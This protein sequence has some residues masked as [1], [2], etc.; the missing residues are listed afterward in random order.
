MWNNLKYP[1]K[2]KK[3]KEEYVL[4]DKILGNNFRINYEFRLTWFR[5]YAATLWKLELK[6]TAENRMFENKNDN[7]NK[8]ST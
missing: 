2:I 7:N 8:D 3:R 1:T 4:K 6:F 5:F